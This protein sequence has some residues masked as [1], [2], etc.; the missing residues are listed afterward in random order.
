MQGAGSS[1]KAANLAEAIFEES[2]AK[3]EEARRERRCTYLLI[4]W[5]LQLFCVIF[6]GVA[7]IW[8]TIQL[9]RITNFLGISQE[10][11]GLTYYVDYPDPPPPPPPTVL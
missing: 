8:G 9:L 4:S 6:V 2:S 1:S 5:G 10:P 11:P 7:L 3:R